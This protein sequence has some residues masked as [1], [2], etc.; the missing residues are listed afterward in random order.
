MAPSVEVLSL[1]DHRRKTLVRGA[2]FERF[3]PSGHLVYVS[4]GTL[5]SVPFELNRLEVRGTPVPVLE[6]VA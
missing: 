4:K 2:T 6:E 3:L 5:F 1:P